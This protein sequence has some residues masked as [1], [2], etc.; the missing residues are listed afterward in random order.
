[1]SMAV[2]PPTKGQWQAEFT[3]KP[4]DGGKV[5]IAS[6]VTRDGKPVGKPGLLVALGEPA[7]VKIAQNDNAGMEM[8]LTVTEI[9][10]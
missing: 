8:Q 10:K 1:M 2:Q 9:T 3:L 7:T 6:S 5:Y 4:V